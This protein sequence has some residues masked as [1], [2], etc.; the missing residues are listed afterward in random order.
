M[1]WG[2]RL[3]NTALSHPHL[4]PHLPTWMGTWLT[5]PHPKI[6][7]FWGAG[8]TGHVSPGGSWCDHSGPQSRAHLQPQCGV[9]KGEITHSS[10]M[11]SPQPPT[12]WPSSHLSCQICIKLHL[13]DVSFFNT[14][15]I[16]NLECEVRSFSCLQQKSAFFERIRW[17][18]VLQKHN[19]PREC[20]LCW[21]AHAFT[22]LPWVMLWELKLPHQWLLA[23][24]L[25]VLLQSKW[26]SH[27]PWKRSENVWLRHLR[28]W[29]RDERA[30]GTS[31]KRMS[32]A[33]P[34]KGEFPC[35][36]E[37]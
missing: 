28:T 27:Y 19:N 25:P 8:G 32:S 7:P 17:N 30:K 24:H 26:W 10:T 18:P 22:S 5:S 35:Q 4:G 20:Q 2:I 36:E 6:P 15:K 1:E 16:V 14:H 21:A 29:F 13:D 33:I 23:L 31:S 11:V 12:H 37:P 3:R 34:C 9:P